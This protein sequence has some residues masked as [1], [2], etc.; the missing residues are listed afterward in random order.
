MKKRSS[1]RLNSHE[2]FFDL[3]LKTFCTIN[4]QQFVFN[5][6]TK[7]LRNFEKNPVKV[8]KKSGK[9]FEFFN[10]RFPNASWLQEIAKIQKYQNYL[11]F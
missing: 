11:F 10:V 4:A 1:G 3:K 5:V 9:K 7:V 6:D 8:S 2:K